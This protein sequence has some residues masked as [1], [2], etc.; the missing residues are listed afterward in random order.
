[1]ATPRLYVSHAPADRERVRQLLRPI[2][3]LPVEVVFAGDE[4]DADT[5]RR[6]LGGQ[7]AESDHL[8]VFWSEAGATDPHVN[9]EVGFATAAELPILPIAPGDAALL[10]FLSDAESVRYDASELSETAFRLLA[11]LR[12]R[13]EPLGNLSTPGWFLSFG[14]TTD[15]CDR[16][17]Q[18]EIDQPQAVLRTVHEHDELLDAACPDCGARYEFDPLTLGFVRAEAPPNRH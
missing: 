7:V 12:D 4:V 14:C 6:E 17:V 8:L 11:E 15:D 16:Q 9:Q 5:R 13:L 2:R 10:G 18:L 1:M 3:N